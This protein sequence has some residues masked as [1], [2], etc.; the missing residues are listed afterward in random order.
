MARPGLCA[1]IKSWR[2]DFG[3]E[4]LKMFT[5][6]IALL[7]MTWFLTGLLRTK[8]CQEIVRKLNAVLPGFVPLPGIRTQEEASALAYA[9]MNLAGKNP[10]KEDV[11]LAGKRI[12]KMST[13]LRFNQNLD[14]FKDDEW[15]DE[16]VEAN[17]Q[18]ITETPLPN[19]PKTPIKTPLNKT[20]NKG[21]TR[22]KTSPTNSIRK[23]RSKTSPTNSTRKTR[24]NTVKVTVK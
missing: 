18:T 19:S 21:E 24:S 11:I 23:T 15:N 4:F 13:H 22:N 8:K 16:D 17:P 7:I 9:A 3:Y 2:E 5:C 14:D 6:S 12:T 10:K 1:R 20:R